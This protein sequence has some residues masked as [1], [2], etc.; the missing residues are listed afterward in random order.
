MSRLVGSKKSARA[1]RKQRH[2][3]RRRQT[4]TLSLTSL[5]D[6]FTILVFFL[7]VSQTD[8]ADIPEDVQLPES[9]AQELPEDMVTIQVSGTRILVQDRQIASVTDV[10]E[11]ED[12][13]I[14]ELV[15]A[16]NQQAERARRQRDF[17]EA[18]IM[19]DREIPYALLERIMISANQ[20]AYTQLSFAVLRQAE[21]DRE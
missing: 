19:A 5:M 18:M 16:L 15:A 6:I 17:R 12:K 2:Y 1:K 14:P 8:S 11:N 7:L 21:E 13:E 4:A 10:M 3:K 20:T 9:T